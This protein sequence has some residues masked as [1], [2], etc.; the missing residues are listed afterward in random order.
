MTISIITPAVDITYIDIVEASVFTDLSGFFQSLFGRDRQV[1]GFIIGMETAIPVVLTTLYHKYH[2]NLMNIFKKLTLN[3][4]TILNLPF[5]GIVPIQLA[6]ITIIDI[7]KEKKVDIKQFRSKSRNCPFDG[8]K[9]K[10]W[11]VMTIFQGKIVYK[12]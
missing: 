11:P 2:F 12:E 3:P 8:L 9:L 7:E 6:D 4:A 5:K 1:G 10:G